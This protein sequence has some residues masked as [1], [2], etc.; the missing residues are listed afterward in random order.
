MVKNVA[1]VQTSIDDISRS[2]AEIAESSEKI[3]GIVEALRIVTGPGTSDGKRAGSAT[4]A[5]AAKLQLVK[6]RAPSA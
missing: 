3:S 5:G 2:L 1:Q 6:E 4:A